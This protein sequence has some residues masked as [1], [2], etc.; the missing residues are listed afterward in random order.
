MR[1]ARDTGSTPAT[2]HET[3]V[4][5]EALRRASGALGVALALL[6]EL[7]QPA[8]ERPDRGWQAEV[9]QVLREIRA[10]AGEGLHSFGNAAGSD[11]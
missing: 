9:E 6:D 1:D 2:G 3:A 4:G 8:P 7:L 10:I 5:L 11:F